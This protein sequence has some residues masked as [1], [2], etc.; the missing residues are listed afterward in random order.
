MDFGPFGRSS[1]DGDTVQVD[2]TLHVVCEIG[3]ADL[4]HGPLDA[5]A[6]DGLPHAV[7]CSAKTCSTLLRTCDLML[8]ARR[9]TS[10]FG[11]PLW[12]PAM[13]PA[14]RA[15]SVNEGLFAADL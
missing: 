7:F 13:D 9:V 14:D 4:G 10:G 15:L 8:L 5:D 3:H 12:L 2:Q 1:S 11:R 6:P